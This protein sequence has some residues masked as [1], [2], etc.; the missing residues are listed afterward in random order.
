[1]SEHFSS[2]VPVKPIS[3]LTT[4][5][6][7]AYPEDLE[8]SVHLR[9]YWQVLKKRHWW[10]WG[11]LAGMVV[12]TLLVILLMP[13]I[14]KVTTTLQIIQDN[15]SALMGDKADPLGAI[16]GSSE[17][18][19][20]YETQYAIL[21]SPAMAYGLIDALNLKEHPSYQKMVKDNP[22]DP[23]EVIRQKYAQSLLDYLS[24]DPIKKSFLVNIS[25]KSTDKELAR[26]IPEAI[27]KEYVKLAMSTRQQ[28]YSM[29]REWL[30]NELTRLGKKL[31]ISE[32]LVYE[33]GQKKDF[34][35]LEA[36]EV[37]VMIQKYIE[38]SKLLTT[39]QAE[40]AGKEAIYRQI[41][42]KGADAPFITNNP[43]IQQL[44]QQLIALEAQVSGDNKIF[45]SNYPEL[46]ATATKMT[47]LR[48]RL[49]QE[50]KRLTT[51]V[52]ADYEAA[53]RAE[54]L[55][56]KEF[57]LQ[58]SRV[59]DLQND[60]VH[61]H[62][63]K[64]DLQTNQALY[65]GLLARMK[66]ASVASTMVPSNVSVINPAEAPYEPWL[67]KPLLFMVLAVV[68]GTMGGV[69]T[70]FFVEYLDR[71]I[72]STE[73]LEKVCRIPVLGMVPFEDGNSNRLGSQVQEAVGLIPY[74]Q[75]TSL[76]SEAISHIRSTILMS[77]SD[78]P[79]Q[80]IVV[81]SA[82]P[83]EGK[84]TLAAQVAIALA[85]LDRKVLLI[86]A[87]LRKPTIHKIFSLPLRPGLTSY[88]TGNGPLEDIIHATDIA[89]LYVLCAGPMPPNP[90]ELLS[91]KAFRALL[92]QFRQEYQHI[93]IDTP[94]IIGFADSR[95]IAGFTDGAVL[96]FKH[97]NTTREEGRLAVHLLSQ[98]NCR[99]LGGVLTMAKKNR[100]QFGG[101]QSYY[102]KYQN[103]YNQPQDS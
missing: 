89:N 7:V 74:H 80:S 88:L 21:Q 62:I 92:S 32:R 9:D 103:Y 59:I 45:G 22:S 14:Y 102:K 55:L 4:T 68:L 95:T 87:D 27:H 28:S 40:R 15:P 3:S 41:Q 35:A 46:K 51:S 83:S 19:R 25:Y 86:D 12:V 85:R 54:N 69:G 52:K 63:L 77:I 47:E 50:V 48:Q 75:P 100:L 73:E 33:D 44:R 34:L 20:F 90:N 84:S 36:P 94:P 1:M 70:A 65:E 99:I 11:V 57:E 29:L 97:H 91:S 101:Y 31:E 60:L 67:P 10:V 78:S 42:E 26:R 2:E 71:S 5:P 16:T 6:V 8:E 61:H 53:R 64:R 43:L 82:N 23:P 37:N 93:I 38:V 66:E 30:D 79:P 96:A 72:K 81:T 17:L 13:P 18:D 58:K 24:V 98:S 56:Q 39:A 49:N 76:V